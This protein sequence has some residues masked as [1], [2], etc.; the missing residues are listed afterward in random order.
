MTGRERKDFDKE[1]AAWD[2]DPVRIKLAQ[3][4]ANTVVAEARPDGTMD[5]LDFGCGTGLVTLRL[6]PLVKTI[7]GADSSPGM[8]EVLQTK[9]KQ[10]R[11]SNVRTQLVDFEGGGRV[12]GEFHLVVSSMTLH[13]VSDTEA[14]VGTLYR[15]LRPGGLLCLAD[16]DKEDGT[17]HGNTA[18]VFHCG[19]ER[20]R[21]K[22]LFARTG[23]RDVRDSTAATVVRPRENGIAEFP[24]FLI[25]GRKD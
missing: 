11:L 14:L 17:F 7:L 21:L 9:I 16:L 23:L 25:C 19:F 20:G 15:L 3:D 6:Q 10:Q 18:G 5:A 13:H 8:L 12:A 22:D 1:A 24:V 4:V 2:D